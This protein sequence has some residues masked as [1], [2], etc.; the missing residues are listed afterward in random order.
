[1]LITERKSAHELILY[2]R[3][4]QGPWKVEGVP[5]IIRINEVGSFGLTVR[6]NMG[7]CADQ[8]HGLVGRLTE[9]EIRDKGRL[10]TFVGSAA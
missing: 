1:M 6:P 9:E 2:R 3:N 5:T 4:R 7:T 10:R 8:G